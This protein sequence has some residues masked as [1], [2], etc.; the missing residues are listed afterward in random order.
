M[1]WD[2][3]KRGVPLILAV[4]IILGFAYNALSKKPLPLIAKARAV[5]SLEELEAG[6]TNGEPTPG[7]GERAAEA[8]E[9]GESAIEDPGDPPAASGLPEIVARIPESEFPITVSLARTKELYDA[10]VALVLDARDLA[11]FAEGHIRGAQLAPY[12]EV[13]GDPDWLER[14]IGAADV[15]LVYC[16]GG[17]CEVSLN[18]GF[19][20]S[21]AGHR[22]VLVFEG[23]YAAWE[24]AGYPVGRG[25]AP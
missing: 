24:E 23:G 10:G 13:G 9:A 17:D 3:P 20:L 7:A 22:R 14:T 18:L 4:G 2:H 15:L 16:G 6:G 1:N 25:E 21:Q 5:V 19:A 12:D 8:S 11:E